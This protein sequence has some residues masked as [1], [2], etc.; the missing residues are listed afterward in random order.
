MIIITEE[1]SEN[2]EMGKYKAQTAPVNKAGTLVCL[3]QCKISMKYA[4]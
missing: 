3:V 1:R 4:S 2:S